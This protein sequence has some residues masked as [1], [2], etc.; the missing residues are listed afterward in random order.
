M[1]YKEI[2][3]FLS[4]FNTHSYNKLQIGSDK[5]V[6]ISIFEFL[7]RINLSDEKINE[8]ILYIAYLNNK[9]VNIPL[10]LEILSK[11]LSYESTYDLKEIVDI[12]LLVHNLYEDNYVDLTDYI[13][14]PNDSRLRKLFLYHNKYIQK[15]FYG[16]QTLS[17]IDELKLAAAMKLDKN[18]YKEFTEYLNNIDK[19]SYSPF[20]NLNMYL[21]LRSNLKGLCKLFW[22][23]F[24]GNEYLVALSKNNVNITD[25]YQQN[26]NPKE[27]VRIKKEIEPIQL[28]IFTYQEME[29]QEQKA[30]TVNAFQISYIYDSDNLPEL[31]YEKD[32]VEYYKSL[33]NNKRL[34]ILP[35]LK[36][37]K[38][39]SYVYETNY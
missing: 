3:I 21:K 11:S 37:K 22:D 34:L 2:N 19:K 17:Y 12:S 31:E 24:F 6:I 18:E 30:F 9:E 8:L 23:I 38:Y 25:V 35:K 29:E 5:G 4:S 7:K 20:T 32:V 14:E 1:T 28:D 39:G 15:R 33:L 36:S 13:H 10:F 26:F 27:Q 16:E